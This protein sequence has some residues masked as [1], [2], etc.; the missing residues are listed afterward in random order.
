MS[1]QCDNL[2]QR[3]FV[4]PIVPS[5]LQMHRFLFKHCVLSNEITYE[6]KRMALNFISYSSLI[7]PIY[8][9]K[10]IHFKPRGNW[11]ERI[12]SHMH[13][14]SHITL[15]IAKTA[16]K[17]IIHMYTH[18][19]RFFVDTLINF[20]GNRIKTNMRD[21][22]TVC[23]APANFIDFDGFST[24]TRQNV[25]HNVH[26]YQK[27]RWTIALSLADFVGRGR[28]SVFEPATQ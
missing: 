2:K 27:H 16:R 25:I 9:K 21:R 24:K 4:E 28:N 5:W 3:V 10:S 20:R 8:D 7:Q 23:D 14:C 19:N 11:W 1:I 22:A 15:I 18:R 6:N 12:S 17:N 26:R 13:T